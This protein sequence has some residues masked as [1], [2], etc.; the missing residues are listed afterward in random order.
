[1]RHAWLAFA[2]IALAGCGA[3]SEITE[4]D[5]AKNK[6]EFSQENYEKAMIAAGKQKELEEEKA[7]NAQFNQ[8]QG[9][10]Q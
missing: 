2:A 7:R 10:Q 9:D 6:A 8:G 1:M 3:D 4:S 5:A